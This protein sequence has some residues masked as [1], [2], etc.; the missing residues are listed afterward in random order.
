MQDGFLSL[1]H[2]LLT[3][4]Q[5]NI[6]CKVGVNITANLEC[7]Q[8]DLTPSCLTPFAGQL[9]IGQMAYERHAALQATVGLPTLCQN[10]LRCQIERNPA[11]CVSPAWANTDL[12]SKFVTHAV[13][14]VYAMWSL[15]TTLTTVKLP[16]RVT[17]SASAGTPV[18][19]HAPDG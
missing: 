14:E 19:M 11:I 10:I 1:P 5:S 3:F 7:L 8:K 17:S 9:E 13:L 2:S 16:E 18:V 12:P 4:L 15:Y 6:Y